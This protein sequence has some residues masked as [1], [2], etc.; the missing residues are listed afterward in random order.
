MKKYLII[1][2]FIFIYGTLQSHA[3]LG[4]K[5][6]YNFAKIS[7][8]NT[9]IGYSEKYLKNLQGGV[10]LDKH[11]IPLL[12]V[13][14]GLDY[15]PKGSREEKGGDFN[16]VKLNYLELPVL[17]KLKLGS[18]Y[19]LGGVYGAYAL[20]GK[21]TTKLIG[22]ETSKDVSFDSDKIKRFDYGMK[23]GLGFQIGVG[24]VHIFA[25]GDYSFGLQNINNVSGNELKNN[26][27]GASVGVLLGFK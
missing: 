16:Q 2:L 21:T 17:A 7:G 6:G 11:I 12:G 1:T 9:T 18:F 3:Q 4:F 10:F 15:T 23:F 25:Q 13:R 24:P 26:V 22:V 5:L 8:K 27:I 14:I 19:G 20:G